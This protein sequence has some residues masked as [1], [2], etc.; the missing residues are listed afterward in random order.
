MNERETE[1][2]IYELRKKAAGFLQVGDVE[3]F[4]RIQLEI[5]QRQQ[6]SGALTGRREDKGYENEN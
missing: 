3:G 6:S 4:N 5:S 1:T 2:A